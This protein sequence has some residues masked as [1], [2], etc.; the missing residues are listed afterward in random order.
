MKTSSYTHYNYRT[1]IK[2]CMYVYTDI[3]IC[4]Y[5]CHN[6]HIRMIKQFSTNTYIH[7][8]MCG[9]IYVCLNVCICGFKWN[10]C[11]YNALKQRTISSNTCKY[12]TFKHKNPMKIKLL[13]SN[14]Y[15][16]NPKYLKEVRAII[17]TLLRSW[18]IFVHISWVWS[19]CS[20]WSLSMTS[21]LEASSLIVSAILTQ[22]LSDQ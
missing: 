3:C 20:P 1:M 12:W 22:P 8:S 9:Q 14:K 15:Q 10:M 19:I 7:I 18:S 21:I 4:V 6:A 17:H 13:N 16:Q 2:D 5:M 11:M